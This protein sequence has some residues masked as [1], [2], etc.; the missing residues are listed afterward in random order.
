VSIFFHFFNIKKLAKFSQEKENLLKFTL[1]KKKG[2]GD[3][4][5]DKICQQQITSSH[6]QSF[7]WHLHYY[8]VPVRVLL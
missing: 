4:K 2:G 7:L 8:F 5:N 3:P 1:G 6:H